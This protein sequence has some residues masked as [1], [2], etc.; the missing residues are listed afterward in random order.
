MVHLILQK[1]DMPSG[2][3]WLEKWAHLNLMRFNKAKCKVLH[4]G[5]GNLRYACKLGEELLE[6]SPTEKDLGALVDEK[7]NMSQQCVLVV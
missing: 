3:I 1:E 6:S 5:W 4:L 2:G 7:L